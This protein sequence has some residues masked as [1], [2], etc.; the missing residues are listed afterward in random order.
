M[1]YR[2]GIAAFA[3]L[4]LLLAAC[5]TENAPE[6]PAAAPG[7]EDTGEETA[8]DAGAAS[9][10]DAECPVKIGAS[11]SQTGDYARIAADQQAAYELFVTQLNEEGGLLGCDVELTVYDDRS[12]PETGARLYERLITEDEVDLIMGPYSSA[13]TG[14]MMPIAER[15]NMVNIAPMASSDELFQQGFQYSFQVITPASKYLEGALQI[16]EEEGLK[17]IAYIGEDTAF[18]AAIAAALE[19]ESPKRGYELV[20]SQLYPKGTT[21]FSALISQMG[22]LQPDAIFGGTYAQDAIAITGQLAEQGVNAPIIA[23]TVGAAENEYYESVGQ[24]GELIMGASHWEPGLE[25]PGNQEFVAAYEE[26]TGREPGY[27]AAGSYAG[28]QV[29]ADA[30]RACECLD[31][32]QIR[33]ELIGLETETVFGPFDVD[34]TGA[35]VSKIGF[36]IQWVDGEKQIVWP[37]D[38]ASDDYVVPHPAW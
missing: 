33:E 13:V 9:G 4:T 14:G 10:G 31:Q 37:F 19:V 34:E 16:M 21:D 7:G 8:A 26:A 28:M 17:T 12:T 25:T 30:V 24:T 20:F 27:H 6:A 36:M 38:V 15:Y 29:L 35:Q 1:T 11:L 2:L 23:L 5:A 18:P 3:V 22:Q 32:D